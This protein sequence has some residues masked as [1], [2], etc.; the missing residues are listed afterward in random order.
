M[1]LADLRQ[2]LGNEEL[3]IEEWAELVDS[4]RNTISPKVERLVSRGLVV[5]T[6]KGVKGSPYKYRCAQL[7]SSNATASVVVTESESQVA[8]Q[9]ETA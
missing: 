8:S 3:T 6:G 4:R 7:N 9:T 5:K 1:T 2:S